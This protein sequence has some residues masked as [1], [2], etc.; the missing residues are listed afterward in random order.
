[1]I[2]LRFLNHRVS[3]LRQVPTLDQLGDAILDDYGQPESETDTIATAVAA[4][5]QPRGMREIAALHEAG[6]AVSDTRIYLQGVALRSSDAIYHNPDACPADP[7]LPEATY[8]IVGLGDAAGAG[9]H[10]QIDARLVSN[11][12]LGYAGAAPDGDGS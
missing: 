7:D 1:M 9:H 8:D 6:V 2:G 3:V 5:I 11:P 4:G 10:L 12:Q